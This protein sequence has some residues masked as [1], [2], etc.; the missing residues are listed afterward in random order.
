[1]SVVVLTHQMRLANA[2]KGTPEQKKTLKDDFEKK[3]KKPGAREHWKNNELLPWES[4]KRK[5]NALDGLSK[6]KYK[7]ARGGNIAADPDTWEVTLNDEQGRRYERLTPYFWPV[8]IFK[9]WHTGE[10]HPDAIEKLE[11]KGVMYEGVWQDHDGVSP[12]PSGVIRALDFQATSVKKTTQ[13]ESSAMGV[14]DEDQV[15]NTVKNLASLL[16]CNAE[17]TVAPQHALEQM[18]PA[19]TL[20][21]QKRE[22]AAK[23]S[24]ESS[25]DFANFCFL[26][27]VMPALNKKKGSKHVP[28]CRY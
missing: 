4:R 7:K 5:A 11:F 9:K 22:L 13:V 12:L 17:A 28:S 23:D 20:E 26:M 25:I 27:D 2:F 1:M 18:A 19:V 21:R 16:S 6:E 8:D 15:S 10:I 14:V 24:S 3:L